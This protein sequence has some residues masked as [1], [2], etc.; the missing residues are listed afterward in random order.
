M[1]MDSVNKE[2]IDKCIFNQNVVAGAGAHRHLS[3]RPI[4]HQGWDRGYPHPHP[5]PGAGA[6]ERRFLAVSNAGPTPQAPT[7]NCSR[8]CPRVPKRAFR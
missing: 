7:P 6:N 8:V 1:Q 5:R 2:Q 4:S 3:S